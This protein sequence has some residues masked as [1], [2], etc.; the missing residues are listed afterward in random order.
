[1]ISNRYQIALLLVLTLAWHTLPSSTLAQNR[2]GQPKKNSSKKKTNKPKLPGSNPAHR[3]K[4][5]AKPV[6]PGSISSILESANRVDQLVANHLRLKGL[7]ANPPVSDSVFA[8][9][10]YLDITGTI[11]TAR[12]AAV[13]TKS[14]DPNKRAKLIDTLLNSSGYASHN[15][16]YWANVM[17]VVDKPNGNIYLR[18]YAEWL[19]DNFRQNVPF[20]IWVRQLMT[21]E[22]K[23]W[24]NPATGYLLRDTGMPLDNLANTTRIFLGTRI[25][26]AQ[27]HDHP[28]DTWSQKDFYELAAFFGGVR[29]RDY[30]KTMNVP[31]LDSKKEEDEI[32]VMRRIVRINR[33]KIWDDKKQLLKY[34]KDYAYENAKPGQVVK[35]GVLFG[36]KDIANGLKRREAFA[37][38]LTQGNDRFATTIA[39]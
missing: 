39:N 36:K 33:S 30:R 23:S 19:K 5:A 2:P 27:C 25:G 37:N 12:E 10:V 18:P 38:W 4:T 17:R 11:P 6:N 26:C 35:T 7:K 3:K 13:F 16:N 8:R 9:R 29:T 22:G 15:Y 21:A 28:F 34:P 1:M 14:K 20:D 24:E 31:N 32:Y